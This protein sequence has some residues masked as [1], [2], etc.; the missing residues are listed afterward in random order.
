[1]EQSL[2]DRG[3]GE[4]LIETKGWGVQSTVKEK[5]DSLLCLY[6]VIWA[7]ACLLCGKFLTSKLIDEHSWN[8]LL[9]TKGMES[10]PIETKVGGVHST[11]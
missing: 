7:L 8:K 6:C 3:N 9:Q 1:M 2:A 4:E 10:E 5:R 11:D